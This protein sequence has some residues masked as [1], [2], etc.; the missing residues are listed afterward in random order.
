MCHVPIV[1]ERTDRD[2]WNRGIRS[3]GTVGEHA[4]AESDEATS[5]QVF[6]ISGR[7]RKIHVGME[8]R[9]LCRI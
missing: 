4:Q 2:G 7:I 9:R 5:A 3:D 1:Y 8:K 6:G